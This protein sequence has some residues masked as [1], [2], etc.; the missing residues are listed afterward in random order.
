MMKG[1]FSAEEL[2]RAYLARIAERE[3]TVG[4]W[5]Y[6]DE[7]LAIAQA[8]ALDA[9]KKA[10]EKPGLLH[11]LPVGL[12]DIFDTADMPTE[13]DS[14][15][16]AGRRPIEDSAVAILLRQ[17]GAIILG[18]TVTTE[19]AISSPGKTVNPHNPKHTPGGSSSGSAA[20][21]ADGMVA[22]AVGT[23]TGGSVIRPASYCGVFG[24]KPTFG[25]I[26]RRGMSIL[27][28]R[29]DHVGVFGRTVEDL[30]LIGDALM[31]H[32]PGDWDMLASPEKDLVSNLSSSKRWKNNEAPRF[33][34]V[35]TPAWKEAEG[36]MQTVFE[37]FINKLG[38]I[39]EEVE[40]EGIFVDVIK[41]HATIMDANLVAN[42]GEALE[43]TPEKLRQET[44]RRIEKGLSVTGAQYIQA[45]GL[46]EVQGQALDRLFDHYDAILTPSAPGEAPGD[47]TTTGRAV[48]NAMWTLMGVPA[49][50]IPL[51]E[52]E[53]GLPIGVQVVGRKGDDAK[54]L[55]AA[56]WLW[57]QFGGISYR[58]KV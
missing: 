14:A 49:V 34:F 35:R 19:F 58:G 18:K 53:K 10:G 40:L 11:G 52:G 1:E 12:K 4:A 26:S 7:D 29:L 47:L 8:Q 30:G 2:T 28:R 13:C 55:D 39:V 36:N 44:R 41:C 15:L 6:L 25:S 48:F 42:L 56:R 23:Q 3:E 32:D 24:Y 46:A 57:D 9:K 27:A 20:A 51:L 31:A 45:L 21:I 50:T 43:K 17:A 54:I 16:Y 5:A 37:D 22:L 38:K 33:A